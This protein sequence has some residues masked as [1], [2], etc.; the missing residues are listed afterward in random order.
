MPDCAHID[1]DPHEGPAVFLDPRAYTTFGELID[2]LF[3]DYLSSR[4]PVESYG[5]RWV[6][7]NV[8]PSQIPAPLE[9]VEQAPCP[10]RELKAKDWKYSAAPAE[11]LITPKSWFSIHEITLEDKFIGL[12]LKSAQ[13]MQACL[14]RMG[15]KT[16]PFLLRGLEEVRAEDINESEYPYKLVLRRNYYPADKAGRI[17]AETELPSKESL[18]FL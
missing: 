13:A 14:S 6:L 2:D 10:L 12:A 17:W 3:M 5:D 9:W 1:L 11:L 15:R 16:L 7:E 18:R 8:F 4:F